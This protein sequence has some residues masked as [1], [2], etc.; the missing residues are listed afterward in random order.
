MPR[1]VIDRSRGIGIGR[2]YFGTVRRARAKWSVRLVGRNCRT[3]RL[4]TL[5][6]LGPVSPV[7]CRESS[8]RGG[9]PAPRFS[10][11]PEAI[12]AAR[13]VTAARADLTVRRSFAGRPEERQ[14][15]SRLLALLPAT[16]AGLRRPLLQRICSKIFVLG[17]KATHSLTI[18][19]TQRYDEILSISPSSPALRKGRGPVTSGSYPLISPPNF[20]YGKSCFI[21]AAFPCEPS[22]FGNSRQ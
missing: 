22:W 6:M 16:A 3:L 11:A 1:I 9:L 7:F 8:G 13:H 12:G 20:P 18:P 15:L 19:M 14:F 2:D 21:R 5:P 10:N 17:A 4:E